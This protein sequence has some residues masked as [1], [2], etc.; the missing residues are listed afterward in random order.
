[1]G[2]EGE[3][4]L[5]DVPGDPTSRNDVV[6]DNVGVSDV[7][8]RKLSSS[9]PIDVPSSSSAAEQNAPH[10]PSWVAGTLIFRV[11]RIFPTL[12]TRTF[13]S[14]GIKRKINAKRLGGGGAGL[15]T[16]VGTHSKC[17]ITSEMT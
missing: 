9:D 11:M 3:E 8:K 4:H 15:S 6:K 16:L 12:N 10:L 13:T 2:N 1:M 14:A 5:P 17:H 7:K